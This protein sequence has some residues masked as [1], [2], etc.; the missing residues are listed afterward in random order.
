M[1][2]GAVTCK[3]Q[4]LK[5]SKVRNG[6]NPPTTPDPKLTLLTCAF[7]SVFPSRLQGKRPQNSKLC[8]SVCPQENTQK[9]DSVSLLGGGGDRNLTVLWTRSFFQR[10]S[11]TP[12]PTALEKVLQRTTPITFQYTPPA[13]IATLDFLGN[14]RNWK[15]WPSLSYVLQCTPI[16]E[17][18][19]MAFFPAAISPVLQ[20]FVPV[21]FVRILGCFGVGLPNSPFVG[22]PPRWLCPHP[23][24]T[25]RFSWTISNVEGHWSQGWGKKGQKDKC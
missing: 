1:G 8:K 2:L 3:Q 23:E 22:L 6:S 15:N 4:L 16:H 24:E 18:G 20:R 5:P 25:L 11:E 19:T 10:V 13:C 17:R 21:G 7:L 9:M 14:L 12:P